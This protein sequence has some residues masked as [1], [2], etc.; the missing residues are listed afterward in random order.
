MRKMPTLFLRSEDDPNGIVTDQVNPDCQWVLDGEGTPYAKLDGTACMVNN[1]TLYKRYDN[2]KIVDGQRVQKKEP[3]PDWVWC[4]DKSERG[5]YIYWIPVGPKDY[6]H[7]IGWAW[8]RHQSPNNTYELIGPGVQNNPHRVQT[9][10]L[11]AHD[12]IEITE[13]PRTYELIKAYLKV[14]EWEGIVWHHPDGRYAKITK[15]K[16]GFQWPI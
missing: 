1:Y 2:S 4:G 6:Y 13:N 14:C 10:K 15:A 11:V 12:Y 5:K 16:F 7:L 3:K 9:N 8:E